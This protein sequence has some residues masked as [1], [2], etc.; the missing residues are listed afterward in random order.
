MRVDYTAAVSLALERA[1]ALAHNEGTPA[2][3]PDHLL[4][5]LLQEEEGWPCLLLARAG[6]VLTPVRSAMPLAPYQGPELP[7]SDPVQAA[8]R[9]AAELGRLLSPERTVASEQVLLA[10]LR[11]APDLRRRLGEVGMDFARLEE[12]IMAGQG[13][14]LQLD[15]P[16][17]LG[18]P[19]EIVNTARIL[20]ASAN[21]AR[22]AVRVL[23]DY[24]RFILDDAFLTEEL[25]RLRHELTAALSTVPANL[26]LEARDTPGDV[27]TAISTPSEHDRASLADVARANAKRLQEAL[28]SLEEFGKLVNPELGQA[29]EACR[30]RAYT[31]E[32]AV[33]LGA[34]ARERLAG[35]RLY[36]LVTEAACRLSLAGTI[37]EALAGGAQ[38]VQLREKDLDDRTLLE[39]AREVRRL[40]RRAGALFILNDRPDLA[41]LAQADGVHLGQ[42]DLP[43]RAARRL[44]G[45]DALIGVSTHSLDQVRRAVL[46][47]ASYIGV[48]PVFTSGTKTFAQ[49]P[50]LEFVRQAVAE[51][52]LPAFVIGGVTL[53]T[54]PAVLAAGGRRVAVSQAICHAEYPRLLAAKMRQLLEGASDS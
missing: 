15:E 39:R 14:P 37:A 8:L 50:G 26:L 48:G 32:Q 33:L 2:V 53:E 52:S 42:D 3:Q 44:L 54:L 47:G 12:E 22:E 25:K 5:G 41:V 19:R 13:P 21:R 38:I 36:V 45:P 30:Y 23:E 20:D 10:L 11:E 9:Q 40:T 27:G 31:L 4:Q 28:R 43:V 18:E 49:F 16:L 7:W 51:T 35:A 17:D 1:Q 6:A 24:C 29:V 46:D 34:G